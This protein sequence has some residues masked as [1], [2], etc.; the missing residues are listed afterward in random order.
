MAHE[1]KNIYIHPYETAQKNGEAELYQENDWLNRKCLKS[2]DAAISASNY[3]TN[4]YDLESAT[5]FILAVYGA[6]R[7][8]L[9]LATV[10]RNSEHDGRYSDGNKRWACGVQSPDRGDLYPQTHPYVL[11]GFI[12]QVREAQ[13]VSVLDRLEKPT[14]AVKQLKQESDKVKDATKK[15][16]GGEAI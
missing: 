12:D 2:I 5:K 1:H 8:N 9:V 15:R 7:V 16:K 4:Y 10:V 11:N 6:D 3:A 13:K 14:K